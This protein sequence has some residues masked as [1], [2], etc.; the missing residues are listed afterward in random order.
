MG[1]SEQYDV[2]V[3]GAGHAG[4]E[5]AMA[6]A[7][8][9]LKTALFTLNLDLIAQMSCNPAVGGIAKGHLVREVDALGGIMGEVT[10]AVGIQFRLLNTSRGPAVWSPR[11][12]C[13][14]QQ[15]RLQMRQ[16]LESQP[17]LKIKQAEVV[18]LIVE[19]SSAV[20][21]QSS[22]A[23]DRRLMTEDS[24]RICRGIVLRDGRRI[25]AEAVVITTGT[26]LNGLIHCGE[27]QIPAGRSGEPPSVLLGENIKKLGLRG[28]R[29]KTGTPPRLDGRT[30]DWSRFQAQPG[31][32]DPTPF[33]F[34]TRRVTNADR[35]V[36][37]YI[38]FTTEETHRVIRENVHRSPMYSGQ[39]KSIGPRYCP[40][41]EDKIV[42]FPDKATHQLF[43]EPEGL[44]THEIYVNGMST[45]LPYEVQ[46]AI[47]K[48]IPGLDEADMLRPGY[49]IEYDAI[50][51]TELERTL[52]TRQ[53]AR[54]YLAGQ[55]NGTSGYEEA[56]CQGIMA[57]INAALAVKAEPPL[58]LDRTEAYTA[59][60]IDDLISKGTNEPYRMFTSR[61]EFRLHLRIDNADRRLTQYGRRVGLIPDQAWAAYLAKQERMSALKEVLEKTK[62]S[63]EMLEKIQ[64]S[65][66]DGQRSPAGHDSNDDNELEGCH[67]ERGRTPESKDPCSLDLSSAIG[68][69]LSQLLKRPEITIERLAL[70]LRELLP[71]FF[72][73]RSG[74]T[75]VAQRGSAGSGDHFNSESRRDG[76]DDCLLVK[77][78]PAFRAVPAQREQNALPAEIRNELKSVETEVKYAGYLGQQQ[79]A[80]ERLKK[81]EQRNIP[82]W[83]NYGSVSGLS[84]EMKEKLQRVRPRTIGQASR[85]PGVTPAAV[86]LINVYIEI[87]ARRAQQAPTLSSD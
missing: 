34:R 64:Q 66:V 74:D 33:S 22:G 54:L 11:A 25:A 75:L 41:I 68:A 46:A 56:A 47:L 3:V 69:P 43:L 8:M 58:V 53:I 17:N 72:E 15:Y 84:R 76:T 28:C 60:L 39:I 21:R 4:C 55:I 23:D 19:E 13:D 48:T 16:V 70:V 44:N 5:A 20:S 63:G 45:S 61:A 35:Q 78:I 62:L 10:D 18:D 38:A 51:P 24:H 30:I 79:K 7:R 71:D 52:E 85:I 73:P 65:M 26:F 31:D 6:A 40:S 50:D 59:I 77:Q 81:A 80:I 86:S 2:A 14:K 49:A 57:G 12:Q 36:P 42:K 29:L 87:Q 37:C 82:D 1:F 67:P 32:P 83:F 27:Q 9:G